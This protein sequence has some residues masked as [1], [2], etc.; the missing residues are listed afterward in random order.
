M[1]INYS[2]KL[3]SLIPGGAHTYSRGDDQ[4]PSN[5]PQIF[6]KGKGAYAWDPFNKRFLDYGMALRAVTIGYAN[7]YINAAALKAM[8]R[9]VNLTRAT[10][11]ELE[12]AELMVNL[13]P[14]VDM[15]KFA[16]NGSN[17]TTAAIKIARAYTGKKYVCVPRQQPFFSFDDWFI[18]TTPLTKGIPDEHYSTTLL[19]D[20]NDITSLE[21]LFENYENEIAAV[22]MEPATTLVPCS[23][24]NCNPHK[25]L[26]KS[27]KDTFGCGENFLLQVQRLCRKK[28]A[29]FILDE[30]ITGFRW[31]LQGAQYFYGVEPDLC[32]FG[33]GMANGFALA[34]LCGKKE[35]MEL[36]GIHSDGMERTFLV[37]TTHGAEMPALGAFIETVNFYRA[38]NVIDHLWQY[39]EKLFNGMDSIARSLGISDYFFMEGGY[40]SMNYVTKDKKGVNSLAFRTLFSQELIK[41]NLLMPWIAPSFSHGEIELEITLEATEKAL[42][43]YKMALEHGI[44]NYLVGPSIKPVFRKF[45]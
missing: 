5:A 21:K 15:V 20:Y 38:N 10:T 33:K 44:E 18:G 45:N 2:E 4:Y 31:H 27:C 42:S 14:S 36:G 12:A 7:E 11:L 22:I 40:V 9:G 1:N 35:L 37:S 25:S 41:N 8:E 34:A 39:G 28:G 19:F 23:G 3:R 29:I 6:E 32:T 24:K 17:V 13:V 26:G 16:K 30:M 43:I